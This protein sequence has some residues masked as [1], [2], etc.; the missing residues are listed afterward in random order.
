MVHLQLIHLH[1]YV[2]CD[3]GQDRDTLEASFWKLGLSLY[4]NQI[5][6]C[7]LKK[8]CLYTFQ[9]KDDSFIVTFINIAL[10]FIVK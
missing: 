7:M 1:L 9:I 10:L 6:M 5:L 2:L 8:I 4:F 3:M